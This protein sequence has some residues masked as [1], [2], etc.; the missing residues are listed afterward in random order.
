MPVTPRE[1]LARVLGGS[2]APGAFSAAQS[3]A[4]RRPSGRADGTD[5]AVWP[6][7]SRFPSGKYATTQIKP[8]SL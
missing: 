4:A 1:R 8:H 6:S 3:T 2:Q 5:P 7:R